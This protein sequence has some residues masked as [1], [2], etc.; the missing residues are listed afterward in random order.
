MNIATYSIV[1]FDQKN[2]E[3]GVAVQ[4]KFMGVG[5]VVPFAK[6]NVGAIA[7]QAFANYQYGPE[8][9]ELLSS[10]K[11][12]KET[13]EYLLENDPGRDERQIGI[14]DKNGDAI[15]FTGE[16]CFDWAGGVV[17]NGFAVQGNILLPGTVEAMVAAFE[18]AR[19]LGEGELADWLV[20]TLKAAERAGGD[21]RGRQS[22]AILV[23]RENGGYGGNNDHYLDLRVDDHPNPVDE[24]ARLVEMHHLFFGED[25]KENRILLSDIAE[26]LQKIMKKKGLYKS[27]INGVFDEETKQSFMDFCGIENLEERWTGVEDSIDIKVWDFIKS[28]F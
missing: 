12:A 14:V 24:L 19:S 3:W 7:T 10:G 18:E 8:G 2:K 1:A 17:G 9:L 21:R 22:A 5:A 4:S 11:T 28:R 20:E 23:V 6:A 27:E 16:K 26:D 15:S 25:D 13:L